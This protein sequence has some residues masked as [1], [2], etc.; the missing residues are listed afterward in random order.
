MGEEKA[1]TGNSPKKDD[2]YSNPKS[3]AGKE[4]LSKVRC[5]AFQYNKNR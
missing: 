2:E 4:G 5:R 3:G 1:V